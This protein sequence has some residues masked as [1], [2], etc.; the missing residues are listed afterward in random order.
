MNRLRSPLRLAPVALALLGPALLVPGVARAQTTY[1]IQKIARLGELA[2]DTLLP[3]G[4]PYQFYVAALND[5]GQLL[6]TVHDWTGS[7][8]GVLLQYANGNFT[9]IA[10][11]EGDGPVGKWPKDLNV[12]APQGMTQSGNTVF[13]LFRRNWVSSLGTFLWNA[14]ARQVTPVALPGMPATG[15]LTFTSDGGFAPAINNPGDIVLIGGVK[16]PSS[17]AG[18][19]GIFFLG[20]DQKLQPVLLTGQELPGGGKVDAA[21]LPFA[22]PSITD[23]GAVAFRASREGAPLRHSAYLWEQGTLAPLL[24]VGTDVPGVGKIAGVGSV[25]PNNKNRAVLVSASVSGLS[26]DGLYRV[27]G[28]QILPV[29]VPGREM[30][31]GGK[32]QSAV[33]GFGW[34]SRSIGQASAAGEYA[35]RATLAGGTTAAYRMDA[36]GKVS[37]ILK[38]GTPSELGTI[39]K[40][41]PDPVWNGIAINSQGQV[42]VAVQ[43]DN[44]PP[45]LV[46]LTPNAP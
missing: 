9:L 2:G 30:P 40:I 43:I 12:A 31:G 4:G 41:G 13:A 32:I 19:A 5:R 7:K 28:D 21:E 15:D 10:A 38:S 17:P 6:F 24:V 8:P 45:T 35:F 18:A 23:T 22:W 42:A 11:P 16:G 37:L 14:G 3:S 1:K 39:T 25:F 27:D 33:S 36:E 46:L 20:R 44:G 29:A 34:G 26:G